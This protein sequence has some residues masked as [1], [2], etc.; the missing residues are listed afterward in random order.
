MNGKVIRPGKTQDGDVFIEVVYTGGKL[1][2]HGVVGPMRNGNATGSAGQIQD[3][4]LN[5]TEYAPGWTEELARKLYETWE[6]WHLNDMRAACVHQRAMGWD[7]EPIDP[8]QPTTAYGKFYP[9][10]ESSSWNL[11]AWAYPPIGH[12]TE[13]CPECGYK[14]GTAWLKEE[15]PAEVIDFLNSLPETDRKPAW[16]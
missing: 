2:L 10:Q 12:L 5:L 9:G 15:V 8:T 1:S 13:A 14:Y 7:K 11:K 16:V 4:L 6:R 3:E